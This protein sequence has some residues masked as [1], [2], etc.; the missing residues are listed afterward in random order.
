MPVTYKKQ[1]EWDKLFEQFASFDDLESVHFP[2]PELKSN[3][4]SNFS[5][6]D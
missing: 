5:E 1:D 3:S 2:E 6:E 4:D